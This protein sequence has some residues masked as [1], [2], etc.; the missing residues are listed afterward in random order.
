MDGGRL[1]THNS[2]VRDEREGGGVQDGRTSRSTDVAGSARSTASRHAWKQEYV[3]CATATKLAN[4]S[5]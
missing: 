3:G 4:A 2:C 5:V 1:A